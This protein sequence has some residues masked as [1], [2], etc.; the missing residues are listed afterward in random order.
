M[1]FFVG[2]YFLLCIYKMLSCEKLSYMN[3]VK[4][5][6][7]KMREQCRRPPPFMGGY[8]YQQ[9]QYQPYGGGGYQPY[10]SYN[11]YQPYPYQYNLQ[12]FT[13]T[14]LGFPFNLFGKK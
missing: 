3:L 14:T 5:P 10:P 7:E 4:E 1:K 2:L 11:N 6:S 13:S 8:P 9:P 12:Q